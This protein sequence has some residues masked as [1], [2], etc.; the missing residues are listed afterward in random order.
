MRTY[1]QT[2]T[3]EILE[4]RYLVLELAA[5]LDRLDEAAAREGCSSSDARLKN[6]GDAIA[7][8]AGR[9]DRADRAERILK[10]Y[11]DPEK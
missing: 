7:V 4:S 3:A 5:I 11:S 9:S 10:I 8:I 1:D 2:V 6:L